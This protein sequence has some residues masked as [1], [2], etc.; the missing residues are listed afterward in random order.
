MDRSESGLPDESPALLGDRVSSVDER[1]VPYEDIVKGYE[2][3]KD[4]FVIFTPEE[5][6]DVPIMAV[7]AYAAVGD[8]ERFR[9]AGAQA[10]VSKPISVVRFV[11]QVNALLHIEKAVGGQWSASVCSTQERADRLVG[12]PE[13]IMRRGEV[14]IEIDGFLILANRFVVFAAINQNVRIN[15]IHDH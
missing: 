11:E 15:A 7:T 1:D 2:F 13:E 9:A 12:P 8:D 5:L 4:R 10:Y 14:R 3:E 6:K